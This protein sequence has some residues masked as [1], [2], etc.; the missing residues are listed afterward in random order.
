MKVMSQSHQGGLSS[1]WSLIMVVSQFHHG[2][3]SS[4]WSLIMEVLHQGMSQQG[5]LSVSS[6]W[7]SFIKMVSHQGG[8]S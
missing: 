3:L 1:G 7:W 5:G 8:L 2:G 6:G 4:G